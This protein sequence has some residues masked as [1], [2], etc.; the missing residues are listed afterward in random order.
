MVP[1]CPAVKD[2]G[3]RVGLGNVEWQLKLFSS[4]LFVLVPYRTAATVAEKVKRTNS[5]SSPKMIKPH[6]IEKKLVEKKQEE[7]IL[8]RDQ[9]I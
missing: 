3:G 4:V 5:P 7:I 1:F 9:S 6:L 2:K 8:F